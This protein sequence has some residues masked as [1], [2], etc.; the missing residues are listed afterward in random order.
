MSVHL[1]PDDMVKLRLQLRS[2]WRQGR[3]GCSLET[4]LGFALEAVQLAHCLIQGSQFWHFDTKVFR[5]LLHSVDFAKQSAAQ[6][7]VNAAFPSDID[8]KHKMR[9]APQ[10]P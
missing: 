10:Q 4:L 1:M 8:A 6:A 2:A 5:L 9:P 3:A 7:G